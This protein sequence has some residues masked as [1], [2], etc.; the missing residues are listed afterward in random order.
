MA[1]GSRFPGYPEMYMAVFQLSQITDVRCSGGTYRNVTSQSDVLDRT[2]AA[3]MV[4]RVV[5][6][7]TT[8]LGQVFKN[9]P[10]AGG[11]LTIMYADGGSEDFI[12]TNPTF[13]SAM[14]RCPVPGSLTPG[15]GQ[16]QPHPICG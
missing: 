12:V 5:K 4:F 11:K 1:G 8:L 7:L 3:E 2:M 13:S 10:Y 14:P 15:N 9:K 6:Q 16:V